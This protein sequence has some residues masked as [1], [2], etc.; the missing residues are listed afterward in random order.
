MKVV[1][2]RCF[3]GVGLSDEC[4]EAL[5]G[6]RKEFT[7]VLYFYNLPESIDP[8]GDF[9]HIALRT[10]P[11]LIELMETKGSKWCSG[12]FAELKIVEIPD[13]VDWV[14]TEYDGLEQIEEAHQVWF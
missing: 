14:I 5:S 9:D 3:G 7:S 2:N 4:C 11:K 10:N 13:N 8:K 12:R 1:I 6:T